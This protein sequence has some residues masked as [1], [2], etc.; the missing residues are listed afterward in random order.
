LNFF[1]IGFGNAFIVDWTMI[2]L[3]Q[4][5]EFDLFPAHRRVQGYRNSDQ[6][7]ANRAFPQRSHD[8]AEFVGSFADSRRAVRKLRA[9]FRKSLS[10]E[11]CFPCFNNP[12]ASSS[13]WLESTAVFPILS[14]RS[15]GA[16]SLKETIFVVVGG[17]AG[18][19]GRVSLPGRF[20]VGCWGEA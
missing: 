1:A 8:F 13:C 11:A 14:W 10:A 17:F 6:A 3:A 12:M 19:P 4:Q 2:G 9:S 15:G 5:P 18:R 20:F 16:G 7:K